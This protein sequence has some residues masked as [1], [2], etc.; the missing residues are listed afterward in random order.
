V[1]SDTAAAWSAYLVDLPDDPDTPEVIVFC[2]IC[3]R[4]ELGFARPPDEPTD[5]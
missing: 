4:R 5:R 1:T 3:A 2:P